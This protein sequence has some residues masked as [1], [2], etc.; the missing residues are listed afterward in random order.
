VTVVLDLH[1][2]DTACLDKVSKLGGRVVLH[3]SQIPFLVK[4]L[5]IPF[6]VLLQILMH[7]V[8]CHIRLDFQVVFAVFVISLFTEYLFSLVFTK[9]FIFFIVVVYF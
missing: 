1:G 5:K 9:L 2:V 4:V 3:T 6:A 8:S 7:Q